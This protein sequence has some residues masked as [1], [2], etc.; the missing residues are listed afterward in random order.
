MNSIL[1]FLLGCLQL[2]IPE[3]MLEYGLISSGILKIG[4]RASPLFDSDKLG[5][6]VE[7]LTIRYHARRDLSGEQSKYGGCLV[8]V[9]PSI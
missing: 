3:C 2:T 6:M 8:C 5:K 4:N 1:A 7:D 9:G